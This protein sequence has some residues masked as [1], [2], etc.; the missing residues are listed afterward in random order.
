MKKRVIKVTKKQLAEMLLREDGQITITDKV[1]P[2]GFAAA[3]AKSKST[4][5]QI[6]VALGSTTNSNG[7]NGVETKLD[8]QDTSTNINNNIQAAK[9]TG[10]ETSFV[11]PIENFSDY[12]Q[13]KTFSD[14][15]SDTS[16]IDEATFKKGQILEARR[17]FLNRNAK[18]YEKKDFYNRGNRK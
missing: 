14:K 10:L 9:E 18:T 11:S 17:T 12:N 7:G 8:P 6:N 1:S 13:M 15:V 5:A 2:E 4:G 3:Q 16:G